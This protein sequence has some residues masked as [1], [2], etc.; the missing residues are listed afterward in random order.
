MN[1]N[2]ELMDDAGGGKIEVM[3]RKKCPHLTLSKTAGILH[4]VFYC[5]GSMI[6]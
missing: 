2:R 5:F 6:I 1:E 4:N 3:G